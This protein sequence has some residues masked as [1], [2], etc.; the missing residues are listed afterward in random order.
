MQGNFTCIIVDDER[1]AIELLTDRLSRLFKNITIV[2]TYTHW[3][4][5]LA[6][7][8]EHKSDLLLMDISMPGKTT[9][10]LL[11]LIPGLESEIVFITAHDNY[12]IDAFAFS[13]SGYLLKPVDDAEL[14]STINKAIARIQNKK[15]AKQNTASSQI[16]DK[17]GIPNNQGIDYVSIKDILYLESNNKC[18]RIATRNKEY[19]SSVNLGKFKNL[20]DDHSFFQV[21]RSYIINLNNILR[22][23]T[24]GLVIMSDKKEIP[25]S[26][27][28]K[29]NFLKIFN[30]K[31]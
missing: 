19:T 21:H 28:I 16:N 10:E 12:A 1:D 9:L 31:F 17:I 8:L 13:A 22:Y 6:G 15:L 2:G 27:N 24:S 29:S 26:R 7:I 5:A 25:V 30:S 18:T 20:I 4:Q 14:F 23:E 3:E 11:K